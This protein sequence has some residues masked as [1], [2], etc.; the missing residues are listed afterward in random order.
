MV[1]SSSFGNVFSILIASCWL[2]YSPMSALQILIQNLLYDISQIAIPWDRM[3][4]EFLAVPQRWDA[5]DLL[6]FVLVLGPTSSTIDMMTFSLGWFYYGIK[7][8]DDDSLVNIFHTHWFLE[9]LLT[10]T[11]IV[12]LL[13]TAKIP[14]LQSN[15]APILVFSTLCVMA[16]GF[17]IPFI[18][19]FA[20]ALNLVHPRTSFIGFLTLELLFYCV[21]VQFVKMLYIKLFKRWL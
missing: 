3:D 6:R 12:H 10:Q 7:S 5:K 4:E 9:G 20:N 21:E 2:P 14:L 16:A 19:P 8:A 13:R 11:L 17:S 18:P 15:A 1:I